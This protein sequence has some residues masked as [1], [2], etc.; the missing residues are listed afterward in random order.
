MVEKQII[1]DAI[2]RLAEDN[3]G[4]APGRTVFERHTRI[5]LSDWYPHHWLRWGDAL[6]AAGYSPNKLQGA[7][8]RDVIVQK[9]VELAKELRKVPVGGEIRRKANADKT[10]PSHSV[11]LKIGGKEKLMQA[12]LRYCKEHPGNEEVAD[13]LA[14]RLAASRA[15]DERQSTK[16]SKPATGFV[17]LM[18]SGR[19]FKIGRTV[20]I[21]RREREL[22]IQIPVPPQTI[23]SIETDDPIGVEAYWHKRF[24]EKRGQGEWFELTRDDVQAF[25][26]WKRIA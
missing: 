12:A 26:R 19:H 23:H 18:K 25:R 3:G 22:K 17:Y 4:R 11:F 2:R 15:P 6:V 5:S 21:G 10:F 1:L 7:I 8:S 14:D 13:M 9:F 24:Q 16:D 20:S